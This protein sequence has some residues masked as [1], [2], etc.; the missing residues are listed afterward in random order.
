LE[1]EHPFLSTLTVFLAHASVD[2]E[3]ADAMH[4]LLLTVGFK[5]TYL[6]DGDALAP[7]GGSQL[8]SD[9]FGSA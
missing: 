8:S 2:R 5:V 1:P 6:R 4:A 7:E 3:W 9:H